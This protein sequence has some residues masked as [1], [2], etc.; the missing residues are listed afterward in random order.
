[1]TEELN[2]DGLLEMLKAAPTLT[3]LQR[4]IVTTDGTVQTMLSVIF[5]KK[6]VVKVISQRDIGNCVVRWTQL[7]IEES[8]KVVCLAESVIPRGESNSEIVMKDIDG[9]MLGI[10]QIL[11][12][13]GVMTKRTIIG[14]F[15]DENNFSRTYRIEGS[16][17]DITITE[18]F[19][20]A[21]YR[22]TPIYR[23]CVNI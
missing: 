16:V 22:F 14:I 6:V 17:T 10:G 8:G 13:H 21:E 3:P 1:M 4:A 5:N 9:R 20:V 23:G 11:K 7:E 19:P 15:G 2:T 12:R 18:V